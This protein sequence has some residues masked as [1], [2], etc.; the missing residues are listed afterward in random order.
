[1]RGRTSVSL[2]ISVPTVAGC[3]GSVYSQTR[4]S[5]T[6]PPKRS[7]RGTAEI[8]LLLVIPIL[9]SILL[10]SA[11]ALKL[12]TA[13]LTNVFGAENNAYQQVTTGQN[14]QVAVNPPLS[15]ASRCPMARR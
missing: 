10:L 11:A 13:R 2:A 3:H 14:V 5:R 9:L 1:M 4:A 15:M 6:S 7:S 12:G 8:E